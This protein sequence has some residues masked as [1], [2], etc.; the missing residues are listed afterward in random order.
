[1]CWLSKNHILKNV[2]AGLEANKQAAIHTINEHKS[3][4][5]TLL[6]TINGL[7]NSLQ[8]LTK[9]KE[10]QYQ[11]LHSDS[12]QTIADLHTKLTQYEDKITD[13]TP[14]NVVLFYFTGYNHSPTQNT[15]LDRLQNTFKNK[16]DQF[17]IKTDKFVGNPLE[18]I[19]IGKKLPKIKLNRKLVKGTYG[20]INENLKHGKKVILI[21]E[22]FG[23]YVINRIIDLYIQNHTT[24]DVT[25]LLQNLYCY[26]FGSSYNPS[27]NYIPETIQ[28]FVNQNHICNYM[29]KDDVITKYDNGTPP[30]DLESDNWVEDNCRLERWALPNCTDPLEIHFSY[31][32]LDTVLDEL[33]L[34]NI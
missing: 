15:L 24:S 14:T 8:T 27:R 26:T 4:V 25:D 13:L 30:C 20:E 5:D 19:Q 12:T 2:I 9:T 21:G 29:F 1:M 7:E 33:H 6:S 34:Q 3:N 17:F 28:H 18:N 32:I 31:N 22:N 23:G 16:V 10:E 11:S